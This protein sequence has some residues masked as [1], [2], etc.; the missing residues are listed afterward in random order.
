MLKTRTRKG[1]RN[2]KDKNRKRMMKVIL[3]DFEW[4]TTTTIY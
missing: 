4:T 3:E 1:R 2:G